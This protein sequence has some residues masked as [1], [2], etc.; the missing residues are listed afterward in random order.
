MSDRPTDKKP[1]EEDFAAMFAAAEKAAPRGRQAKR[2][3]GDKVRGT[4]ASIGHEV[5]VVELEDGGEGTL[6]TLELRGQSGEHA[7]QLTVKI[8]DKVEARVVALGEKAGFVYLRRGPSRGVDPRA[9]LAEAAATGL[10]VEGLVTGVNKGGLEVTVGGTRAFCPMSQLDLRP[11][12]DPSIFVGQKLLFRVTK[13]E[14]DRR[15]PNVVVSRRALLEEENQARAAETRGKMT[16]GAVMSG[17]VTALKDFGAFVDVGGIEGLLPAS[18]IG[19][20]RGTK[21]SDVLSVGQPVTVQVMRIEKRDDPRR[22]EQVSFSLKALERDPW[23][24]AVATLRA[25][26]LVKGRVTRVETF[27]AFIELLPGVEGL[28]HIGELGAGKHLR[29]AREAAKPG[30]TLEVTILSIDEEKRRISLGLGAREDSVDDE[31]RAAAARA[32]GTGGGLGT[33]GDLLK[34]KLPPGR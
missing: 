18:E 34:S 10:P 11:V 31:G 12:A 25:G 7:G 33:L 22:P 29:H 17:V 4:V 13:F 1:P 23:Q 27:G 6:E 19:Y 3:V 32:G 28:L 15:G 26:A 21:P 5:T 30:D 20:Q 24:D 9:G 14:D 16:V 2:A 8:G